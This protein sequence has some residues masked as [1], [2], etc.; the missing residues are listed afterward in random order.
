M[1]LMQ[2]RYADRAVIRA[3]SEI[4]KDNFELGWKFLEEAHIFSQPD[5][6]MHAY[7]HWEMFQLAKRQRD[8]SEIFGQIVRLLLAVPSSVFR[9]YPSG[10]NGRSNVGLF[11]PIPL[12]RQ[13]EK[14]M[15]ELEKL[16]KRRI[17]EGGGT[18]KKYQRQHPLTRR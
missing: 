15:R 8:N 18:L 12:S 11:S 3:K 5:A 1:N 13:N 17:E 16:E 14:K 4:E 10:N 7:V 6:G 2:S 9:V